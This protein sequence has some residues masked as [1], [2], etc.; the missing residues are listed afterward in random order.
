MAPTGPC[1]SPTGRDGAGVQNNPPH[2]QVPRIGTL[3]TSCDL[4][5]LQAVL[6]GLAQMQ[7]RTLDTGGALRGREAVVG[8]G[9]QEDLGLWGSHGTGAGRVTRV[10]AAGSSESWEVWR[11]GQKPGKQVCVLHQGRRTW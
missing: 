9:E 3:V 5:V 6:D 10:L 7:G 8:R 2:R 1:S 4:L 11:A